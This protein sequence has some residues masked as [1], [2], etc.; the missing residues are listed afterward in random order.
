MAGAFGFPFIP[1]RSIA[2]SD[3]ASDHPDSFREIKDP[4]DSGTTTGIVK[5]LNPDISLIHGCVGDEEGNII[6]SAPY[7]DD[8]W[9]PLAS[10]GGVIATVEKIVPSDYIRK[11]AA[12]VKIPGY[13]VKSISVAPFGAHPFSLTNPGIEDFEPYEKD[14]EFLNA[15]HE[16]SVNKEA[17]NQWIKLWV[18]ECADH[19]DY[20]NKIGG[21][22]R[23]ALKCYVPEDRVTKLPATSFSFSG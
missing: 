4:F 14:S 22:K 7:G 15:L 6:L 11:Y 9:G 20:L 8:L 16:A 12:L 10:T 21:N 5:S 17:L 23:S 19:S 1:T 2:G 3:I 18:T 13:I